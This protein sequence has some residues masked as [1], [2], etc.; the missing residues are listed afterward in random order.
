MRYPCNCFCPFFLSFLSLLP[1]PF[2]RRCLGFP[3]AASAYLLV[4]YA[5]VA[6][7]ARIKIYGFFFVFVYLGSLMM[8]RAAC[9]SSSTSFVVSWATMG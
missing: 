5:M 1:F 7:V 6:L 9:A 4:W 3:I 8:S 2:F